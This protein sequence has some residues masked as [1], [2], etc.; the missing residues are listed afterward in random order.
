MSKTRF[1]WALVAAAVSATLFLGASNFERPLIQLIIFFVLIA[2]LMWM[3]ASLAVWGSNW[4]ESS[5][6]TSS[7]YGKSGNPK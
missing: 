1:R 3:F 5:Q 4:Y 6:E 7:I 2:A